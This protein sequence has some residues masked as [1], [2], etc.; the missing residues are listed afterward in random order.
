MLAPPIPKTGLALPAHEKHLRRKAMKAAH[1]VG[2]V[3]VVTLVMWVCGKPALSQN[4]VVDWNNIAVKTITSTV[5]TAGITPTAGMTG[6]YLAYVNLAVFDGVN[7]IHP[8]FR[9]YGGIQPQTSA[10]SSEAAAV[11]TAAHDVLVNYFPNA[12][13]TLDSTYQA[14]LANLPDSIEA[15]NDGISVGHAAAAA[16]IAL[17][18][19]DGINGACAYAQG[20]GPGTYESTPCTYTYGSGPGVYQP[21]PPAFLRAQTPWIASMTP[22]TMTSSSQFRPEEGP[23][24]LDSEEWVDD[25]NRTK[26]WGSLTNSARTAEQTT[27]GLFWTP[28]PGPPF[29][30]M[31]AHLVADHSLSPLDSARLYAMVWTGFADGFI[32]CMDAK[33]QYSFWRPVTAIRAGG[34]NPE[35]VA[36]PSWTPLAVTPNHPEYPAAHGCGTGA[37]STIVAGYFGTT[38]VPLSVTSTYAVPAALGGGLATSTRTYSGTKA[39]LEEVEAARIYGGMHY[40]HSIKQGA[41]LGRKVARQLLRDFFQP[42]EDRETEGGPDR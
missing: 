20:S 7:A 10:D 16:L 39:L 40:H 35:L 26:L 19:G 22:F 29:L 31:L 6:I 18:A 12:T 36:D 28:N 24:P 4:A 37:L 2:R 3:V 25:Y 41:I 42:L 34:G 33:Y 8:G 11:A 30:S 14:Y 23:T 13:N 38:E 21:T 32:G 15:K 27:I 1:L 5:S 9:A 17:R